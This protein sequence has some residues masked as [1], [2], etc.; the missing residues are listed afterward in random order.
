MSITRAA[1]KSN[2]TKSD[3]AI[4]NDERIS[5]KAKGIL[6]Y[7]LTKPND[8][9]FYM[10]DI[11]NKS[12]D[13]RDSIRSGIKELEK[14][15]YLVIERVKENGKFVDSNWA[16]YEVSLI[17][18][19]KEAKEAKEARKL[20]QVTL[21]EDPSRAA[22]PL[23]NPPLLNTKSQNTKELLPLPLQ[24]QAPDKFSAVVFLC[25][26]NLAIPEKKK[27]EI[28]KFPEDLVLKAKEARKFNQVTLKEDPTSAAPVLGNPPLLNTKSQN[29]KELLPLPLQVQAPDKFSAAVFLCLKNLAIPE[30]KKIEIS[31]FPEDLVL[32]AVEF[33]S[34]KGFKLKK[35]LEAALLWAI[36]EKPWLS[37]T[38]HEV[39]HMFKVWVQEINIKLEALN[40]P[41][42]VILTEDSVTFPI[43]HSQYKNQTRSINKS[44]AGLQYDHYESIKEDVDLYC[45]VTKSLYCK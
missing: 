20:N 10:I 12:T 14:F 33:T 37:T 24:V 26:K 38:R 21:K 1:H 31:K 19:A 40:Y 45:R 3:N 16:F 44:L 36:K 28:S 9:K 25:L 32:K 27:I 7:A 17:P 35:T 39:P 13:E 29:T 8:W 22:P 4:A 41:E 5:W 18:E 34:A 23:G 2:Y 11:I 6:L 15:G 30:K 43:Y 42:R